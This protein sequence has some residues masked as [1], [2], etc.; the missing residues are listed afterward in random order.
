[1]NA[2]AVMAGGQ[3]GD[4]ASPHCPYQTQRYAKGMLRPVYF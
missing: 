3:G 4:P 1:M 2:M